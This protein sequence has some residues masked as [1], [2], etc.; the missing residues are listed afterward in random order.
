LDGQISSRD[1]RVAALQE[2]RD[3]LRAGLDL[4]VQQR[5]ADVADLPGGATGL[6]VRGCK[7]RGS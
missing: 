6:L 4:V 2:R 1:A 7:G 3:R 5:G